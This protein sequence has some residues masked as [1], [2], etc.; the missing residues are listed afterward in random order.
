VR[1]TPIVPGLVA[2]AGGAVRKEEV[3]AF[4]SAAALPFVYK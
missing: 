3:P 2:C 1:D 4:P